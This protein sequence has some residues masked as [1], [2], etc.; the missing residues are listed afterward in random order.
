MWTIKILVHYWY[1]PTEII[2]SEE[3][4]NRLLLFVSRPL[5]FVDFEFKPIRLEIF[6]ADNMELTKEL[7][8][9][10]FVNYL[11]RCVL[12]LHKEVSGS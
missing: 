7:F 3:V 4:K 10:Y 8:R 11:D 9:E 12:E 6:V 5:Y 1:F 2:K